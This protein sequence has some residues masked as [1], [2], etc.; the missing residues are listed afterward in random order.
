M[1]M[2]EKIASALAAADWEGADFASW[3]ADAQAP[4]LKRADAVLEAL[5]SPDEEMIEAGIR[6]LLST[7]HIHDEARAMFTAMILSAQGVSDGE[8]L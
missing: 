4:L 3:T 5:L 8:G 1:T 6:V 7:E 2:R